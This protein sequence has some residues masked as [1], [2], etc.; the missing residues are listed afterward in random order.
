MKK[1]LYL[2][3]YENHIMIWF[4]P[5]KAGTGCSGCIGLIHHEGTM[6]THEAIT[7]HGTIWSTQE[8]QLMVI[9]PQYIFIYIEA[10]V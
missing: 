1:K 6:S 7:H 3:F 4:Q 9:I 5:N 10:T 2:D 8:L